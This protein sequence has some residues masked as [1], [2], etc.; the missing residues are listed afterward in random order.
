MIYTSQEVAIKFS[1]ELP[2]AFDFIAAK[3]TPCR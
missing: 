3:I 2:T 1:S